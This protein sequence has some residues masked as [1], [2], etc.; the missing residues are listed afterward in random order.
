MAPPPL[1]RGAKRPQPHPVQARTGPKA[2]PLQGREKPFARDLLD[3]DPAAEAVAVRGIA[4]L[5]AKFIGYGCE[6]RVPEVGVLVADDPEFSPFCL[7]DCVPVFGRDIQ[8]RKPRLAPEGV[9]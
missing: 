5:C 2:S 1:S 9:A 7:G 3:H 4:T 8:G 6:Y